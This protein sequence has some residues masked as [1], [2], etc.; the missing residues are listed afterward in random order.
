MKVTVEH[1]PRR[2]VVLSIEAEP[3]DLE[4]YRKRAYQ[5]LVQRARIPGFRQG[6]APMAML[7]RYLGKGAIL[8]EAIN[9]LI[10]EATQKAIEE[11][12]LG[13]ASVPSIKVDSREP[14][15]W[16]ATVALAPKIDLGSYQDLRLEPEPVVVPEEQVSKVLD[17]LRFQHTPWQPVG[18]AA[19]M[20][21]L[22]LMDVHAQSGGR[23]AVDD[24]G[25]QYRPEPGSPA[26]V[27]GFAE[28]V[29]GMR[30]GE[31]KEFTLTGAAAGSGESPTPREY[32]FRVTVHEVKGKSL[33]PLDDEFAKGAGDGYESL[34]ALRDHVT[35]QLRA[36]AEQDAREALKE[37]ALDKL[38]ETATVEFSESFVEHEAEHL[39]EEHEKRLAQN[40]VRLESYLKTIGK[41]REELIA[42]LKPEA[43]RRVLRTLVLTEL[44]EREGVQVTPEEVQKAIDEI[45][46]S[47][48]ERS[49]QLERALNADATRSAMERTLLT[50]KTLDRLAEIVTQA[51]PGTASPAPAS[52]EESHS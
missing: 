24:K 16:K 20:G 29:T 4:R 27:P 32:R 33:P 45:V 19:L 12:A 44:R 2:E 36:S 47:S 51:P 22:L 34:Q 13:A 21:D 9:H 10:P 26:P 6:K 18:R 11:Q 41:T 35:A 40:Q 3:Q 7:E 28:Q 8:E 49:A 42:D 52:T 37:K 25:V 30:L 31:T 43:Q 17:E 1:L 15:A 50:R 48:Q 46:A 23:S 14:V 38:I 5:H 39:M